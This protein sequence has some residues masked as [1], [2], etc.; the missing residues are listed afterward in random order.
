[1]TFT[2]LQRKERIDFMQTE[3]Y[4]LSIERYREKHTWIAFFDVDEF[5]WFSE[6]ET[7]AELLRTFE[8]DDSVGALGVKQVTYKR[9]KNPNPCIIIGGYRLTFS[10]QMHSSSNLLYRPISVRRPFTTCI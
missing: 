9:E 1:M 4:K 2:Y 10:W 7:L 6:K 3:F 5:L 8:D